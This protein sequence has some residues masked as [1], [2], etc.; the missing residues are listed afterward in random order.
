[1]IMTAF[2]PFIVF[3]IDFKNGYSAVLN[4]QHFEWNQTAFSQQLRHSRDGCEFTTQFNKLTQFDTSRGYLVPTVDAVK[5]N[6]TT[7]DSSIDYEEHNE[8]SASTESPS[9]SKR[10]RIDSSHSAPTTPDT[11]PGCSDIGEPKDR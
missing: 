1:M 10:P 6:S 7:S 11:R 2:L 8:T 3:Q 5:E 9:S 4:R